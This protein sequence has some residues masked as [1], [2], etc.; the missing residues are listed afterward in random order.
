MTPDTLEPLPDWITLAADE[1]KFVIYSTDLNLSGVFEFKVRT[2]VA[3]Y[4]V[5]ND[6]LGFVIRLECRIKSI[7]ADIW[8]SDFTYIIQSDR[9][10]IEELALPGLIVDPDYCPQHFMF[11]VFTINSNV[12]A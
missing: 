2:T 6:E 3:K 1:K 7:L 9:G 12:K 10:V 5:F 4:N 11:S 8:I